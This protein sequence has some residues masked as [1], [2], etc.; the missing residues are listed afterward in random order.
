[1]RGAM[2]LPLWSVALVLAAVAPFVARALA[3]AFERRAHERTKRILAQR[4]AR[5]QTG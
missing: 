3:S 2:S 5:P 1:M 4:P